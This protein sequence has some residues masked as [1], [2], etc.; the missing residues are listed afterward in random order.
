MGYFKAR[1]ADSTNF[2][3]GRRGPLWARRYD[4]EPILDD[5]AAVDR[6]LYTVANAPQSSLVERAELWPGLTAAYALGGATQMDFTY[7]DRTAWHR[8]RRPED[9]TPYLRTATLTFSPL[10]AMKDLSV[11]R[12]REAIEELVRQ[13]EARERVRRR[14]AGK[15]VMGLEK[16]SKSQFQERPRRPK[17]SVRPYFHARDPERRVAHLQTMNALHASY[18][19]SAGRFLSGEAAVAFPAGTYPPRLR[20]AA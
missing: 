20:L 14:D 5:D 2:L 13:R 4:A 18:E 12:A 9:V 10:D 16:L 7:M 17:R 11:E 8:A 1:V 6:V 19:D 15:S 3:L